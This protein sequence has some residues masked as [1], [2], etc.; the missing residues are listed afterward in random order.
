MS[1]VFLG[2]SL[3]LACCSRQEYFLLVDFHTRSGIVVHGPWAAQGLSHRVVCQP[4]GL[5]KIET[6][7]VK[8]KEGFLFEL[9]SY[10]SLLSAKKYIPLQAYHNTDTSLGP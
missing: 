7:A 5:E 4:Q 3:P 6:L 2:M 9:S 1:P 8:L 10:I